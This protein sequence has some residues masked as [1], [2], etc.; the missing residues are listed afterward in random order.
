M[1]EVVPSDK[2]GSRPAGNLNDAIFTLYVGKSKGGRQA[3]RDE[4]KGRE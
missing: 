1:K 2:H 3:E 4:G